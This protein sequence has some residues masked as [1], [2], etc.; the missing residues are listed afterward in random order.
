MKKI[1]VIGIVLLALLVTIFL[2]IWFYGS[3]HSFVKQEIPID[4]TVGDY[5]GINVDVDSLHFGTLRKDF[6]AEKKILIRADRADIFITLDVQ[7]IPFVQPEVDYFFLK[8]GASREVILTATIDKDTPPGYYQGTLL[9]LIR[10][11]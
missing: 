5:M 6:S 11:A 2:T 1:N 3:M 8:Q 4:L 9:I 10:E 7:D